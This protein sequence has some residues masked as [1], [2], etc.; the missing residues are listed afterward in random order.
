LLVTAGVEPAK[1]AT[2]PGVDA[3]SWQTNW[4]WTYATTFKYSAPDAN[5]TVN[6][7]VTAR[8]DSL[9]TYAGQPAYKLVL[10]GN[11]TGG[12]G[13][14]SGQSLSIQSGSVSGH[15]YIRRSDLALLE[16]RQ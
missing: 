6:E 15:R 13:S 10:S 7:T 8:V 5:A 11:V 2:A 1:A 14:A 16:E 3:A 9:T 12:S 4:S